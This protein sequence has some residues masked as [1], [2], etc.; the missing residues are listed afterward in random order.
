VVHGVFRW[1]RDSLHDNAPMRQHNTATHSTN[2]L[3]WAAPVASFVLW[4]AATASLVA[5]GL[6]FWPNDGQPLAT[7]VAMGPVATG[8]EVSA[9]NLSRILGVSSMPAG[10][11]PD[12]P[13]VHSRLVLVG[14]AK[15]GA[16][17]AALI[18]VDGQAAKPFANPALRHLILQLR[19]KADL[20][21]DIVTQDTLLH[22]G[23]SEAAKA[24]AQDLVQSFEGFIAQHKDEITALQ[25][26]LQIC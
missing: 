18:A 19:Q 25:I 3:S 7:P 26:N 14:I 23:F 24:H 22:A 5:W 1:E 8:S 17:M 13:S 12:A 10:A 21:V 20:V 15:S 11:E 9:T 16:N 4:G 2:V 6:A